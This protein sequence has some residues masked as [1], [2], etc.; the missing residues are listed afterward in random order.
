MPSSARMR[1]V[2]EWMPVIL[3]PAQYDHWLDSELTGKQEILRLL[4]FER[5]GELV[6]YPVST[7]VNSRHMMTAAACRLP[8]VQEAEAGRFC[9]QDGPSTMMLL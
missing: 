9:R 6:S 8:R 2:H 3:D 7:W 1:Q 4:D 5:S